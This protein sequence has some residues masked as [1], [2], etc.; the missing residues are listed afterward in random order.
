MGKIYTFSGDGA[1]TIVK[2]GNETILTSENTLGI[3]LP[4][5][6]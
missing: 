6:Y 1:E 4:T 3:F 5:D 2:V